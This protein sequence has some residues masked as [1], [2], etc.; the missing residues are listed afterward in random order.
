MADL[1]A[2]KVLSTAMVLWR[3]VHY[4]LTTSCSKW[5]LERVLRRTKFKGGEVVSIIMIKAR[6]A[7]DESHGRGPAHG[8]APGGAPSQARNATTNRLWVPSRVTVPTAPGALQLSA[9]VC[10]RLYGFPYSNLE[11]HQ[12]W[13]LLMA[14]C[15]VSC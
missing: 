1:K 5:K 7:V 10:S 3:H 14:P 15:P 8:M 6:T 11:S 2:R 13:R 4:N 12:S 9:Y